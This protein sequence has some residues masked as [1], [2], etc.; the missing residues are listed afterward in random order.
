MINHERNRILII[1]D[2]ASFRKTFRLRLS[3]QGFEVIVANDGL[4][5]L[6]S[7][8]K[9]HPDLVITDIMLPGLDGHKICR[10]IKFDKNF[11]HIPVIVLTSRDL[12]EEADLAKRC[13]ADAFIVK[14]TRTPI[15]LNVIKRLLE[16]YT[17]TEALAEK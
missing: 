7:V 13:N 1:D 17:K 9:E 11:M 15:V 6:N 5:G 14:N 16:R 3:K 10:M 8:R 12:D 2:N 4:E